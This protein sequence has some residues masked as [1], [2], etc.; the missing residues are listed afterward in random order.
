ML[1]QVF[2][3][4][5]PTLDWDDEETLDSALLIWMKIT[6]GANLAKILADVP[7]CTYNTL[8]IIRRMLDQ[9]LIR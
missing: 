3:P 5:R 4:A 9:G 2:R 7:R 8:A 1:T 6:E